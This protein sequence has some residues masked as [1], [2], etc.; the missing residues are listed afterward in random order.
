MTH[1]RDADWWRSAVVYQVY[2]R[3]F[4]DHDGD[5]T[6]D[7]LG[8]IDRLPYL[9]ELGIDAIWVSPWYPSPM[10]DGGYDVSDYRDIHPDFGTLEQADTFIARAHDHGLRVLIDLVPN[11]SSDRHPWFQAALAAAAR[12]CRTRALHLPGR[13]RLQR[14]H[15]AEQLAGHVRRS[16]LGANH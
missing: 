5:G 3:S 13:C 12:F 4:S 14:Q 2:P 10:A 6:G 11:H 8:I 1:P 16:G 7:I 9:A 15:P